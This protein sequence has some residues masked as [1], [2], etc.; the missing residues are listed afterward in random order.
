[1]DLANYGSFE[2]GERNSASVG[3][4]LVLVAE[5]LIGIFEQRHDRHVG[6]VNNLITIPCVA[7][8]FLDC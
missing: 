2:D 1:M 7:G 3:K 8:S 5:R 6:N 4:A